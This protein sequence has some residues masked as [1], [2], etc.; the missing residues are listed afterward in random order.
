MAHILLIDDDAAILRVQQALLSREGH[1]VATAGNG[2]EALPLLHGAAFDLVITDLIMPEREGMETIQL[3][4]RDYPKTKII[5][6][7]GG[8]RADATDYLNMAKLMGA[9]AILPKPFTREELL[10]AVAQALG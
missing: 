3:L 4:R 9:N 1:Q 7:S 10:A 2:K 8:G 5:A 6:S